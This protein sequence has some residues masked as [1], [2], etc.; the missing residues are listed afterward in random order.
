MNKELL[1]KVVSL[2]TEIDNVGKKIEGIKFAA[3]LLEG[4][5]INKDDISYLIERYEANLADLQTELNKYEIVD[6]VPTIR[7]SYSPDFYWAKY[8]V[9]DIVGKIYAHEVLPTK[10]RIWWHTEPIDRVE[11]ITSEQAMELCGRVPKWED[12]EPTPVINK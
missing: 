12:D 2:H 1:D 8:V 6:S 5:Y 9:T 10:G 4:I 11:E 7:A 3:L